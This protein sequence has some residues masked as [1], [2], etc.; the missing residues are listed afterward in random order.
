VRHNASAVRRASTGSMRTTETSGLM[1]TAAHRRHRHSMA[2]ANSRTRVS[3]N[4]AHFG[5]PCSIRTTRSLLGP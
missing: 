2:N 1:N 5:Q 4:D 3:C